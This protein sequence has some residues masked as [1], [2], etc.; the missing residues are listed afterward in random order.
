MPAW[1]QETLTAHRADPRPHLYRFDDF[2]QART[3]DRLW[4]AARA[5]LGDESQV[6]LA[7]RERA[8]ERLGEAIEEAC[9]QEDLPEAVRPLLEDAKDRVEAIREGLR[10]EAARRGA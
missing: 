5:R 9:A 2:E 10:A 4:N 1:A 8:E 7:D 6:L 3:H